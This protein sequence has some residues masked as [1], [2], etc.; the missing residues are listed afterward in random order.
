[1][2]GGLVRLMAA[3]AVA[4]ALAIMTGFALRLAD[5]GL[6]LGPWELLLSSCVTWLI[7]ALVARRRGRVTTTLLGIFSVVLVVAIT[8]LIR[9]G[10]AMASAPESATVSQLSETLSLMLAMQLLPHVIFTG[11]ATFPA[12]IITAFVVRWIMTASFMGS[13]PVVK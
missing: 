7:L 9:F 13:N 11:W 3:V 10:V 4:G 1:M 8:I 5:F 6:S 12:G 2:P